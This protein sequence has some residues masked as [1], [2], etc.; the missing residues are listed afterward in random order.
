MQNLH[1]SI[2]K[3][4][5]SGALLITTKILSFFKK[6][7]ENYASYKIIQWIKTFFFTFYI[8]VPNFKALVPIIIVFFS[9]TGSVPLSVYLPN[10]FFR[11]ISAHTLRYIGAFRLPIHRREAH[12][13]F[14]DDPFLRRSFTKFE[15]LFIIGP[16][17]LT[18]SHNSYVKSKK[19]TFCSWKFFHLGL[20]FLYVY[21]Y[22]IYIHIYMYT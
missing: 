12:R 16:N 6:K 7:L 21:K 22:N 1:C 4:A 17:L 8:S 14:F 15:I 18:F 10:Y 11:R 20:N 13:N 3:I 19:K 5:T 2:F 9:K